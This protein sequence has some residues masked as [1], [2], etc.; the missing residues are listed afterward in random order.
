VLCA[1]ACLPELTW[2]PGHTARGDAAGV[3]VPLVSPDAE[4]NKFSNSEGNSEG[5]RI[6]RKGVL[7]PLYTL[8]P[9]TAH[10]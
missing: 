10:P 8:Y 5:D 6:N 4:R 1:K 3:E 2:Q 7:P 9:C